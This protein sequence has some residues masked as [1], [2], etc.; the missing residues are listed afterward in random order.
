MYAVIPFRPSKCSKRPPNA[1]SICTQCVLC[2]LNRCASLTLGQGGVIL[3]VRACLYVLSVTAHP[4]PASE[5]EPST[6]SGRLATRARTATT[7]SAPRRR[8]QNCKGCVST[9]ILEHTTWWVAGEIAWTYAA[10]GALTQ[11][12]S[13]SFTALSNRLS[14]CQNDSEKLLGLLGGGIL[15]FASAASVA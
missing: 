5:A 9:S 11:L 14:S 7:G 4:A 10:L 1:K 8:H 15:L 12:V 13:T 3:I 2:S 6:A